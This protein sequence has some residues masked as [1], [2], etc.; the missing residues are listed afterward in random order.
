MLLC[1]HRSNVARVTVSCRGAEVKLAGSGENSAFGGV[2]TVRSERKKSSSLPDC[3][4]Q[5]AAGKIQN[6]R[7]NT[8]LGAAQALCEAARGILQEAND[9]GAVACAYAS[10]LQKRMLLFRKHSSASRR[11]F[12]SLPCQV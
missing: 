6:G 5:P 9:R 4:E 2:D 10:I 7:A 12:P 11:F 8:W 1:N 3:H